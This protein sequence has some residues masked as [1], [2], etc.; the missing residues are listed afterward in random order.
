MPTLIKDSIHYFTDKDKAELLANPYEKVHNAVP[1]TGEQQ[2]LQDEIEN[3]LQINDNYTPKNEE[4]SALITSPKELMTFIKMLPNNKARG[5]DTIDNK[6]IKNL[7]MKAIVQLTYIINDSLKLQIFPP[8]WK[9]SIITSIHKKAKN[10][11]E[12]GSSRPI[13]LL[14]TLAKLTEKITMSRIQK[15]NKKLKINSTAQFGFKPKHNTTQQVVRIVNDLI[16]G[17]NKE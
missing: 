17:F 10:Q 5:P 7:P 16:N 2:E 6:L 11:N 15:I 12:S 1:N 14:N 13:S 9:K 3:Y 8:K 4:T